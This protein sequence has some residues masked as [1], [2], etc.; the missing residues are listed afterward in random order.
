MSRRHRHA[1]HVNHEAWAIPYGDLVTLLLAFFVVMY[2]LS[3]VNEG[4]YRVLSDSLISAF[5]APPR[6]LDPIQV[7]EVVLSQRNAD[8][9]QER[10]QV[11]LETNTVI[12]SLDRDLDVLRTSGLRPSD[13]D[14]AAVMIEDIGTAL[15]EA[16]AEMISEDLVR[17][18]KDEFWIEVEINTNVLFASASAELASES[19]AVIYRIGEILAGKNTRVQVEGHTD[20]RP[21]TTERFPSNW[22]LSSARAATVVRMFSSAGVDPKQLA[23]VGYGEFRPVADNATPEGQ[24]ENRRV[25]IVIMAD[26]I[27]DPDAMLIQTEPLWVEGGRPTSQPGP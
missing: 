10:M 12:D 15:Q 7:G 18:R 2:S 3:S 4:Q 8:A 22:E 24:S 21:I 9:R 16:L 5:R 13:A 1:D 26:R 11:E 17:L 23:A 6:S 25:V 19:R 27:R 20:L 14:G